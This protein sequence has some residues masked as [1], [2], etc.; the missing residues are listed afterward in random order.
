MDHL[1]IENHLHQLLDP[2]GQ[3][4]FPEVGVYLLLFNIKRTVFVGYVDWFVASSSQL[5]LNLR[6]VL[7]NHLFSGQ[8][9]LAELDLP[10]DP[11]STPTSE[12]NM[13]VPRR[14]SHL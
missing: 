7:P 1:T 14:F 2:P 9:T 10:W 6:V 11:N 5:L 8:R 3:T 13:L 12:Q 4:G